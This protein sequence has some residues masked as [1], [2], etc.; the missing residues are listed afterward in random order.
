[1]STQPAI[2]CHALVNN[3]HVGITQICANPQGRFRFVNE[4]LCRAL[5]YAP[6]ELSKKCLADICPN[7]PLVKS[8][9]HKLK[10]QDSISNQEIKLKRQDG[11]LIPCLISMAPVKNKEKKIQWIDAVIVPSV[12]IGRH[13]QDLL[14]SKEIFRVVF[15]NSAV[16]ITVADKNERVVAWNPF[17]EKMAGMKKED[18]FN[19]PVKDLYPAAEWK[20][21]RARRIRMTGIL[22][23]METKIFKKDGK[24][25]DVDLSI[26]V[27]KD[28]KGNITGAIGI[29][30]DITTRK[31]AEKK[32]KD[33]EQK[34]RVI[35]DNSAVAITLL[36][37][38][39][40]IISWNKFTEQLLGMT[41]KD[42]YLRPVST[43]YPQEEWQKIRSENIR[44]IGSKHHLETKVIC[45][46]NSVIDIELSVNVLR[47][48]AS[49]V[50]GSVGIMQDITEEKK[51]KEELIQ[52]KIAAEEANNS[53]S[54]FLANVSHEV[55]T[56]LNAILGMVDMTLDTPLN[57]EQKENLITVKDASHN[58][59][60]LINDILDLS[61][62]EAGK[63]R[64]EVVDFSLR[65][66]IKNV[67]R[68]LHVLARNKG[69]DLEWQADDGVPDNLKGDPVRL[70]QV[71]I[72][73][74][75]NAIKFTSKGKVSVDVQLKSQ[76]KDDCVLI[77]SINDTG[78]GIPQDK[79]EL[80]FDAFT[81]A[82]DSITR[83]Y[84]GTGLGLAICKRLVSLM[85]GDINVESQEKKGSRFF[86]TAAF[87]I[88]QEG[89]KP[90]E[91]VSVTEHKEMKPSE[92]DDLPKLR[93]LLAEDNLVSQ[94]IIVKLLTKRDWEVVPVENG[95]EVLG[96]MSQGSF[97]LILMDVQMPILDGLETTRLI[98]EGEKQT[99]RHIPIIALTARAMDDDK[100]RCLDIGMDG[101]VSKPV[102]RQKL[103]LAIRSCVRKDKS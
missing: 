30:R 7:A 79:L 49:K 74:V 45:K 101:Y 50:V 3:S 89:Q 24:L 56:P 52:A 103:F 70:R 10:R 29:M 54:L 96:Q 26:S 46:D 75:N 11:R 67:C 48:S 33:S 95:Q 38:K 63:V 81:Q 40:R 13:N 53:K 43:L 77:F 23:N 2:D 90:Q 66:V 41:K 62:I 102:D 8:L 59:L 88:S 1:M 36:D 64:L 18:L 98:R 80:I 31:I 69:L 22:P 82:D 51:A 34:I 92:I 72:N 19:K 86:F 4:Y 97:D 32:L 47:D 78:I 93:V 85:G 44:K 35:L 87:S 99:G 83:R 100:N 60:D 20:R 73:L 61:R 5:G 15:D 84:G 21:I 17:F 71:I 16:A 68:G 91:G 55:R 76:E 6:V 27:L 14:E 57:D 42:L 37:D 28:L 65:D 94:R 58:L 39:E 9:I 12:A 25:I